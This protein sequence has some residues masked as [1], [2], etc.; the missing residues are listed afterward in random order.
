MMVYDLQAADNTRDIRFTCA[1][2]MEALEV[3]GFLGLGLMK[4]FVAGQSLEIDDNRLATSGNPK[5][6]TFSN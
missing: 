1:G 4:S 6:A 3:G 2:P 5:M